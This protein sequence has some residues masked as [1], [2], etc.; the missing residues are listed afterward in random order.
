MANVLSR[1][2]PCKYVSVYL[3]FDRDIRSGE[4]DLISGSLNKNDDEISA[5]ALSGRQFWAKRYESSDLCCEF[6]DYQRIYTEN[7]PAPEVVRAEGTHLGVNMIDVGDRLKESKSSTSLEGE[8]P[9]RCSST[10]LLSGPNTRDFAAP[11]WSDQELVDKAVSELVESVPSAR[12]AKVVRSVVH[13][14]P[15]AI[16]RPVVGTEMNRPMPGAMISLVDDPPPGADQIYFAGDWCQTGFFFCMETATQAGFGCADEV[17][18]NVQQRAEVKTG[19][20]ESSQQGA[21]GG[22]AGQEKSP[23]QHPLWHEPHPRITEFARIVSKYFVWP[24]A[25]RLFAGQMD[26]AWI[27]ERLL[28]GPRRKGTGVGKT[29]KN[30]VLERDK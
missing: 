29:S 12:A 9:P 15:M 19:V 4:G 10:G 11:D 25:R 2:R 13:R 17:L 3:W 14:I 8:A 24:V 16:P 22:E 5:T 18:Q 28:G 20:Q 26:G 1:F 6:Y 23:P 7:G 30:L 27:D 21:Q